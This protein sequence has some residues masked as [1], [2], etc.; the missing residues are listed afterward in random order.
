MNDT[1]EIAK[2]VADL[3]AV[4]KLSQRAL[5]DRAGCS[6]ETVIRL[7]QG[8]DVGVHTAQRVVEVLGARLTVTVCAPVQP[9]KPVERPIDAR[10]CRQKYRHLV[11]SNPDHASDEVFIRAALARPHVLVLA[12]F[13]A[14]YGMA[15]IL[16]EWQVVLPA[17]SG[18]A[19]PLMVERMLANFNAALADQGKERSHA[20]AA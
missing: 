11:W 19:R 7:E 13:V 4:A 9:T 6:R 5:A 15:R 10:P 1:N 8:K 16:K 14:E 3:R 12:D 18:G 20:V 17:L 2:R